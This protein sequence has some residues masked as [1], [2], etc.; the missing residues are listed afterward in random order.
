[1]KISKRGR[2]SQFEPFERAASEAGGSLCLCDFEP[3]SARHWRLT[4][5]AEDV[6]SAQ[7]SLIL[8]RLQSPCDGI[9]R[10]SARR[11]LTD[12]EARWLSDSSI[13]V[14]LKLKNNSAFLNMARERERPYHG[15]TLD[16]HS[17]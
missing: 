6:K 2:L 13:A 8:D 17:F 3:A 10:S 12:L 9:S 15:S 5:L 11:S 16:L 4:S 14:L 1:M 7:H